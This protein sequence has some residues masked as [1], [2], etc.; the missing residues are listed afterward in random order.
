MRSGLSGEPSMSDSPRRSL[1]DE[2]RDL[3][4]CWL[5]DRPTVAPM[6]PSQVSSGICTRDIRENPS[7]GGN[8]VCEIA[9][10]QA[11]RQGKAYGLPAKAHGIRVGRGPPAE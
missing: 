2:V 11:W 7:D 5:M 6:V 1:S 8:D 9:V 3:C 10:C 4:G